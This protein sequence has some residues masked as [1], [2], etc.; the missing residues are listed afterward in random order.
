MKQEEHPK[1]KKKIKYSTRNSAGIVASLPYQ[2]KLVLTKKTNVPARCTRSSEEHELLP[3]L[4]EDHQILTPQNSGVVAHI[5][6]ETTIPAAETLEEQIQLNS[7]TVDEQ[8]QREQQDSSTQKRKRGKTKMLNVHGRRER[9]LIVV[10]ENNQPVGPS[11]DVMTE[12]G[13]FLDTLARNATLCPLDIFD[14]RKMDT[15]YDL[16]A[17]TKEKYDIPD[18]SKK[19]TLDTVQAAWRRHKS[20]LKKNHFEA[21]ADDEIRLQKRHEYTPASQFKDLLKYWG[22]EN[23]QE[24]ALRMYLHPG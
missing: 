16:W 24:L 4:A 10:N 22:S 20:T 23:V 12:L 21:Y 6:T 2:K 18:T 13:S 3:N 9:K 5:Q 11:K 15:K 17:Y 14:W 7:T 1:Q 19:W 8:E